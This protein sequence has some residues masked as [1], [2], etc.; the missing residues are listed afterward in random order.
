MK[1]EKIGLPGSV[2]VIALI[3]VVAL[4]AAPEPHQS[5]PS[6]SASHVETGG[7]TTLPRA[8][9]GIQP[10]KPIADSPTSKTI[11]AGPFTPRAKMSFA[12]LVQVH[13][14]SLNGPLETP[15]VSTPA[16]GKAKLTVF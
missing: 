12:E 2:A 7:A 5:A 4:A 6:D 3:Y 13:H 1:P 10:S 16:W 8:T 14:R 11:A 9:G 15:G